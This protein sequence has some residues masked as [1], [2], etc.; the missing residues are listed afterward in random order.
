MMCTSE[1]YDANDIFAEVL[2]GGFADC[3]I[4]ED[5]EF[6]IFVDTCPKVGPHVAIIA[7][8]P[9]THIATEQ[10]PAMV[11]KLA[12]RTQALVPV[13]CDVW[14]AEEVIV[15]AHN[16]L[17]PFSAVDRLH[18][19]IVPQSSTEPQTMPKPS[20]GRRHL[21]TLAWRVAAAIA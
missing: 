14:D 21:A 1:Q 13:V 8:S 2:R 20:S 10:D 7:K 18:V 6:L 3:V 12:A 11:D 9:I 4:C 16:D 5:G 19:L 17:A 15:T